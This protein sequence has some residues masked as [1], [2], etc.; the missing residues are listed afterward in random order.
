MTTKAEKDDKAFREWVQ[1]QPSCVSGQFSEFVHGEGRSIAAHVRR[2]R[3]AGTGYKPLFS[4][5][6]L[7]DAEHRVQS[8]NGEAACLRKFLGG[9][10]H[11]D[12]AKSW[13]D[14]QVVKYREEWERTR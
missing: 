2:S 11:V 3:D 14:E 9:E 7:T 4:A 1:T 13:F 8:N 12:D 10:W 6:P 5:V